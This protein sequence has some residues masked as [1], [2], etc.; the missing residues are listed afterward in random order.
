LIPSPGVG[1]PGTQTNLGKYIDFL[2]VNPGGVGTLCYQPPPTVLDQCLLVELSQATGS[3]LK[4]LHDSAYRCPTGTTADGGADSSADAAAGADADA[5]VGSDART[6]ATASPDAGAD[7]NVG[8][9]AVADASTGIDAAGDATVGVEAAADAN[10]GVDAVADASVGADAVA[11]GSVCI[12]GQSIACVGVGGCAGGQVCSNQGTSFGACVCGPVVGDGGHQS[13]TAVDGGSQQ[14]SGVA[15]GG[16]SVPTSQHSGCSCGSAQTAARGSSI[17]ALA[18]I[19]LM[20]WR[21]RRS[22]ER[23]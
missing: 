16:S 12:P 22:T 13:G 1:V 15:D 9:D 6:D 20:L 4:F 21:R 14:P 5:G 3:G 10:V 11:V 2:C 17:W 18:L 23:G 19:G 7:A 8:I